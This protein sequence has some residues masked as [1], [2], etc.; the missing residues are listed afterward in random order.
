MFI[1]FFLMQIGFACSFA[2]HI[3][4][5]QL[6]GPLAQQKLIQPHSICVIYHLHISGHYIHTS[7]LILH[8]ALLFTGDLN[9]YQ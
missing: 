9:Y 3:F 6:V 5:F 1:V 4:T 7:N 8:P 2:I